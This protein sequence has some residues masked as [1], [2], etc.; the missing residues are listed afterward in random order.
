MHHIVIITFFSATYKPFYE[1][2]SFLPFFHRRFGLLLII[3]AIFFINV[4]I[5]QSRFL[6]GNGFDVYSSSFF[7]PKINLK[8]PERNPGLFIITTFIC[9]PS[10]SDIFI[11][12]SARSFL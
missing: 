11:L 2:F 8:N 12:Y 7:M 10:L 4:N 5:I 6:Y 1:F 3:I 9:N